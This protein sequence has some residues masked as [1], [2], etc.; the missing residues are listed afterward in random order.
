MVRKGN[1]EGER[2]VGVHLGAAVHLWVVLVLAPV[3]H[4]HGGRW[5]RN[6]LKQVQMGGNRCG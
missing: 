3:W 4:R 6:R 1:G 2:W 5:A